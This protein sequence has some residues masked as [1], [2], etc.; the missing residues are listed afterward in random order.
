MKLFLLTSLFAALASFSVVVATDNSLPCPNTMTTQ[1]LLNGFVDEASNED[2]ELISKALLSSYNDV[3]WESDFFMAKTDN[4]LQVA[5]PDPVGQRCRFCGADDR[6]DEV[7]TKGVYVSL[8]TPLRQ[9]CRFCGADDRSNEII[10]STEGNLCGVGAME[11]DLKK[12][13]A[14]FC[15]KLRMSGSSN[16]EKI[17]SCHV[18]MVSDTV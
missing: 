13:E 2:V 6:S 7:R 3:H 14:S 12:I 10:L 16:L 5:I 18:N 1:I 9:R 17:R 8:V 11:G 4:P 15:R